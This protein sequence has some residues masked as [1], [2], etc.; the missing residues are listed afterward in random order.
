MISQPDSR[1]G[2][3]LTDRFLANAFELRASTLVS[4]RKK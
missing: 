2:Q 4:N 3:N 1:E